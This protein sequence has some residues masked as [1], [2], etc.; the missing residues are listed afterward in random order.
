MAVS[1]HLLADQPGRVIKFMG[2]ERHPF[3]VDRWVDGTNASPCTTRGEQNNGRPDPDGQI[4]QAALR[5]GH[6]PADGRHRPHAGGNAAP[7]KGIAKHDARGGA[8]LALRP[9]RCGMTVSFQISGGTGD[10]WTCIDG[11]GHRWWATSP[12]RAY[13]TSCGAVIEPT[14]ETSAADK[15]ADVSERAV[16]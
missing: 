14:A 16:A 5:D 8:G 15:P 12:R 4:P 2:R 3:P 1:R 11:W 6:W 7:A 13:C 9:Q 10:R